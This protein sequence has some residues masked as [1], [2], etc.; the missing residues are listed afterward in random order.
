MRALLGLQLNSTQTQPK[1]NPNS[2]QE[3]TLGLN[4]T[5]TQPKLYC[6][7]VDFGFK[8][9]PNCTFLR[10]DFGLKFNPNPLLHIAGMRAVNILARIL[11][12][13]SWLAGVRAMEQFGRRGGI[14][15]RAAAAA[16]AEAA[17]K[18][19]SKLATYLLQEWS[20]GRMTP[21]QV[22]RISGFMQDDL[23]AQAAGLLEMDAV[24][25]L[26]SLG[27]SGR[28]PQHMNR[29]LVKRCSPHSCFY[30]LPFRAIL[31][32]SACGTHFQAMDM[33]C[34]HVFFLKCSIAIKMLGNLLCAR[35]P[36]R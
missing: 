3:L 1:L 20:W 23:A 8:L 5:Q 19:S 31:K 33:L 35:P 9:N 29:Q 34:P 14:R 28:H 4:S 13:A 11:A 32:Q 17:A 16:A 10:V 12:H 22:Q 26:S 30:P 15:Q 6:S 7:G 21:Q 27:T 2:Y 25:F 24:Q 18:V 36:T